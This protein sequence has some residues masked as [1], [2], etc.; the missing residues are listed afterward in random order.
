MEYDTFLSEDN[1]S[2]KT[3]LPLIDSLLTDKKSY[4]KMEEALLKRC[5][6]DSATRIYQEAKKLVK[7]E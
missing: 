5:C 1:F 4:K 3:L 2:S 7:D 6:K